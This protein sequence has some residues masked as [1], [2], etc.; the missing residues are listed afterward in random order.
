MSEIFASQT[1]L[2]LLVVGTYLGAQWLYS[3]VRFVLLHPL[4]VAIVVIWLYLWLFGVDYQIFM[5]KVEII[6]YMLGMS[7]VALGYLLYENFL[8]IRQNSWP[9]L[10]AVFVGSVAGVVSV[11]WIAAAM[12]ATP[13][14][15][16]SLQPKSITT[17]IALVVSSASGGIAPLTSIV[18][19]IVG[20]FGG[21]AAPYILKFL[22]VKDPVATGLSMGSAAHAMGTARA[23][24][25]GAVEGAV[26]GLAIALMG[27]VT[28]IVIPILEKFL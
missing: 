5:R 8:L 20:I 15:I 4:I 2:L 17:P 13:E 18:V 6:D 24:E 25:I 16:A 14:I 28:S 9:I 12:G 23:M 19:V 22:G 11:V 21:V 1:A 27:L 10:L 26:S 7:V 3:R